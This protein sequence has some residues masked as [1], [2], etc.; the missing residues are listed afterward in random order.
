[1]IIFYIVIMHLN[2]FSF[3]FYRYGKED[4]MKKIVWKMEVES[5]LYN[6]LVNITHHYTLVL[7]TEN[8]CMYLYESFLQNKQLQHGSMYIQILVYNLLI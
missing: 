7:W 5:C 4:Q 8:K 2:L 3:C 6:S 1:M